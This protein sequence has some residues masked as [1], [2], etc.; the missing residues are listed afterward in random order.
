[1]A[2]KR[3]RVINI[4]GGMKRGKGADSPWAGLRKSRGGGGGGGGVR[5]RRP[6]FFS[7]LSPNFYDFFPDGDQP[8]LLV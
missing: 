5:A 1:M 6:G 3:G 2:R 8:P 4:R 7:L